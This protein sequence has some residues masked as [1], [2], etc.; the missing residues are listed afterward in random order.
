M[1]APHDRAR[2]E[3]AQQSLQTVEDAKRLPRNYSGPLTIRS[4]SSPSLPSRCYL[5]WRI[6]GESDDVEAGSV[7]PP[8]SAR[9]HEFFKE[10]YT[11]PD[12]F[13]AYI[14]LSWFIAMI[15]ITAIGYRGSLGVP[16]IWESNPLDCFNIG[17]L[18]RFCACAHACMFLGHDVRVPVLPDRGQLRNGAPAV[19]NRWGDC[20]SFAFR[21]RALAFFACGWRLSRTQALYGTR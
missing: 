14:G 17:T 2:T 3:L 15:V 18:L 13:A 4:I 9:L 21:A 16:S 5:S 20:S 6:G 12:W 10:F 7:K 11:S 19:F 1:S 8:L